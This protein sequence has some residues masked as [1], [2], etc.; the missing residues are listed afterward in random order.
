MLNGL[1]LVFE[2]IATWDR[3]SRAR[4]GVVYVLATT[5]LPLLLLTGAA[6]AYGLMNWGK[7][8]G[9]VPR[10]KIFTPAEAV[11]FE[12]I[13]FGLYVVV[14]L[15][16]VKAIN[17]IGATF[18]ARHTYTQT[19]ATVSYS[20]TPFFVLRF[21]DCLPAISGWVSW[22]IGMALTIAVLYH[23]VPRMM[24]PDPSHAFGLYFMSCL[25]LVVSTG[26]VRL[27]TLWYLEGK[28]GAVRIN[29]FG[30]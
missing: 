19:F 6:E 15:L 23:G 4:P 8:L 13:Q 22:G 20:L 1:M 25:I 9:E 7:L 18:H 27:L 14:L 10:I 2:P 26:A 24:D 28:L 5:V 30:T 16:S 21:L 3:V 12:V 11:G 17:A 29:L